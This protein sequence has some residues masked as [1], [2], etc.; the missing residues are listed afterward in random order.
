[1]VA[2]ERAWNAVP[3]QRFRA[4]P[5]SRNSNFEWISMHKDT[6]ENQMAMN[7]AFIGLGK[8]GSGMARNLMRAG[9]QLTVYNRNQEKAKAF[10][11][12]GARLAS[13]PAD[14]C[15]GAE[16]VLTMLADDAALEEVTFAEN[17]IASALAAGAVHI[18][19]STISTSLARRLEGEHSRRAQHFISAPV[20]GRPEAS[21]SKRLI[22]VAAGG[23]A[24]VER[25]RAL[26]DAIGR[27]VFVAGSEPW[28]ANAI[29]LYGNFMILS[30]V[31]TFGEAFASIRKSEVDPHLFL[32]IMNELWGSPVYKNYGSTIVDEKFEPAGFALKLALKDIRLALEAAED[33]AVPMPLASLIR[34]HLLS[35]LAHGE[36]EID[37]SALARVAAR[38]AGL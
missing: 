20:F 17:G 2:Q 24:P 11:V 1:L 3:I 22:V 36:G 35:A 32:E 30:M 19:H 9:H 12:D 16:A 21:E 6:V 33:R 18:S 8:M 7:I 34:D 4:D 13:S 5:F 27:R 29:K 31:E 15:K 38:N 25:V 28:Q 14:A 37:A 10:V 23:S 26:L